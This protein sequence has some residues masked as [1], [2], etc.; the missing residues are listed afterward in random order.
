MAINKKTF[1][2]AINMHVQWLMRLENAVE[3]N[4]GDQLDVAEIRD[5][6]L[7]QFGKWLQEN[8]DAFPDQNLY[9][10]IK[11]I[12]RHFHREASDVVSMLQG[13]GRGG[14]MKV[15]FARLDAVSDQLL[16]ILGEAKAIIGT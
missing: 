14:N 6:T 4:Y 13:F 12:H 5:D 15:A 16:N 3:L 10:G 11:L 7:C 1:D 9:E 8:A 2:D